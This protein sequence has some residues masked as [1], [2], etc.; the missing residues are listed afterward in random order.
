MVAANHG[1]GNV[2]EG[3]SAD[4]GLLDAALARKGDPL[5]TQEWLQCQKGAHAE[6]GEPAPSDYAVHGCVLTAYAHDSIGSV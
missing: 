2:T 6:Y 3:G 5:D 4:T 1:G